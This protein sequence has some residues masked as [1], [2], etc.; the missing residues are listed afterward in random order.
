MATTK[1]KRTIEEDLQQLRNGNSR[2][3]FINDELHKVIHIDRAN[4]ICRA[5][6]YVQ[7]KQVV[8]LYTD[9]KKMRTPCYTIALVSK[10]M[11]RHPDSVRDA[12]KRG[13]IKKPYLMDR[14]VHGVYCFSEKDIYNVR[15]Y[16]ANSHIGRPRK[17]GYITPRHD[18]PTVKEIDA[19]LGKREMLYVKT[20]DG[21][22]VPVWKAEEF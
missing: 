5:Y 14:F 7:D 6:N 4:N 1:R 11:N 20:K 3:C 16:Y 19:L 22:F 10:I 2:L 9:Y 8:Y 21:S 15:D 17:D 18:V 13:D 12:I